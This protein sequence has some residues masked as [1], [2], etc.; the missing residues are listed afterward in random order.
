MSR[1]S[2][3]PD[4]IFHALAVESAEV[5]WEALHIVSSLNPCIVNAE[6][7]LVNL[8]KVFNLGKWVQLGKEGFGEGSAFLKGLSHMHKLLC[9][10]DC[11]SLF[12]PSDSTTNT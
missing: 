1:Y 12:P 4:F 2:A 6:G 3:T 8:Y 11:D 7:M 9:N 5:V 10:S